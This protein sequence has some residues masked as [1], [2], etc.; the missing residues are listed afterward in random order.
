M[1]KSR[2]KEE[3]DVLIM[4]GKSVITK[5]ESSVKDKSV[6]HV[7]CFCAILA[8]FISWTTKLFLLQLDHTRRGL[9]SLTL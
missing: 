3:D 6:V 7:S 8:L 5:V 2:V 1:L 9:L 4:L